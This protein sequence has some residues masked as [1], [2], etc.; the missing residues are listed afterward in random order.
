MKI[1]SFMFLSCHNK[2]WM[3]ER[4]KAPVNIYNEI[5]LTLFL[6]GSLPI[7]DDLYF[8][9]PFLFFFALPRTVQ[10]SIPGRKCQFFSTLQHPWHPHFR[11]SNMPLYMP[12]FYGQ[13]ESGGSQLRI[14]LRIMLCSIKLSILNHLKFPHGISKI[15]LLGYTHIKPMPPTPLEY[16]QMSKGIQAPLFHRV[17]LLKTKKKYL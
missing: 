16:P 17:K 8:Q 6:C 15:F 11:D 14:N 2:V 4:S 7:T 10:G 5:A 3:V 13:A 12:N 9:T 1:L